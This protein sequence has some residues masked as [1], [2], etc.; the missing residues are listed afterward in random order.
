MQ[1]AVDAL[2]E[3]LSRSI[4][5]GEV[6]RLAACSG[7]LHATAVGL[8]CRLNVIVPADG[9]M[10]PVYV[11][12]EPLAKA[13]QVR[14]VDVPATLVADDT[15]LT[16]RH[17]EF[18]M[19]LPRVAGTFEMTGRGSAAL[20]MPGAGLPE[21]LAP[22]A[23]VVA[24]DERLGILLHW[25]E[26]RAAL[27]GSSGGYRYHVARWACPGQGSGRFCFSRGAADQILHL[28]KVVAW[29]QE[30]DLLY[31]AAEHALLRVSPVRDGYPRDWFAPLAQQVYGFTCTF[32]PTR[33]AFALKV[34][35]AALS[36]DDID[37]T[38]S[39]VGLVDAGV[40]FEVAGKSARE[41][42]SAVEKI[43]GTDATAPVAWKGRLVLRDL[44]QSLAQ[45][46]KDPVRVSFGQTTVRIEGG[47]LQAFLMLLS[48]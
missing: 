23:P 47:S 45:F 17:G 19:T 5:V 48:G 36:N 11:A 1:V 18:R 12:A 33:L 30:D 8:D 3:A 16:C 44:Q 27:L 7:A 15:T 10:S 41:K 6:V 25:G 42:T 46:G 32:D 43:V 13:V 24:K 9:D 37:V 2:Q 26:G 22:V 20:A 29:W 39:V 28:G 35:A 38:V 31:F 40:L 34:A 4:K 21:Q 14:A